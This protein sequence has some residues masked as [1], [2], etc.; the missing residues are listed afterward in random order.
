MNKNNSAPFEKAAMVYVGN[1]NYRLEEDD[2]YNLFNKFGSI[3]SVKILPND[4]GGKKG[5]AFVEMKNSSQA[6]KAIKVLNGKIIAGRTLKV[7]VANNR[8]ADS[9]EQKAQFQNN[10]K[11]EI[12]SE[13]KLVF[14]KEKKKEKFGLDF[15]FDNLKKLNKSK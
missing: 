5:I 6:S 4:N 7:S 11:N 12:R 10:K 2:I 13:D 1:L 15:L 14:K 3:N 9:D 8:Y